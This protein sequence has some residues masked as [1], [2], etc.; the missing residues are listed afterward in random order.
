METS[1]TVQANTFGITSS[2]LLDTSY[3]DSLFNADPE[4][5]TQIQDDPSGPEDPAPAGTATQQKKADDKPAAPVS[6][7]IDDPG[8]LD[9]LNDEEAD[10]AE[11]TPQNKQAG[12][13]STSPQTT[14]LPE[15]EQQPSGNTSHL[16]T[17]ITA[18]GKELYDIGFLTADPEKEPEPI[19]TPE[20]LIARFNQEK[21]K[22]A[23]Q[24]LEN[25]LSNFGP[26]YHQAF[27]AIYL[28]GVH[29]RDYF[30]QADQI[31]SLQELDLSNIE[32]QRHVLRTHYRSLGWDAAKISAKIEK[33]ENYQD[34]EEEARDVHAVLV[35]KE[36]QKLEQQQQERKQELARKAAHDQQ[37]QQSVLKIIS[38]KVKSREFDGIPLDDKTAKSLTSYI[39]EKK[40]QLGENQLS[41]FEKEVLDLSRPENRDTQVKIALLMYLLKTDPLLDTL[42]KKAITKQ[43]DKIF[44]F[45]QREDAAEKKQGRKR[46]NFFDD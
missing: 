32:N 43:S 27:D 4:Q 40:W 17:N 35:A 13:T 2:A 37:Q 22:G 1:T 30:G 25:I 28:D 24:I 16:S 20:Q 38:E 21:Q 6:K 42:Q 45:L 5:V 41:D 11:E 7:T 14:S 29:P 31:A 8:F 39:L 19:K 15:T 33:L 34:I 36:K 26:D 23:V 44:S 46:S 10:K 3:L 12:D 9:Q 18:F